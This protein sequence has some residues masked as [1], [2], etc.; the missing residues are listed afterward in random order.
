M[1]AKESLE[2]LFNDNFELKPLSFTEEILNLSN[3]FNENDL[4]RCFEH[5]CIA[6][7]TDYMLRRTHL[8]WF[9]ENGGK[10]EFSKIL[11]NFD[12][13]GIEADTLRELSEEGL[14]NENY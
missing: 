4:K 3:N 6:K 13:N 8:S 9:N 11:D 2:L 7:P 14:L 10:D 1:I 5:Y 12:I